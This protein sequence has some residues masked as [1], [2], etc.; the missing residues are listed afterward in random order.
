MRKINPSQLITTKAH[1]EVKRKAIIKVGELKS[2][3]QTINE[4]WL[5]PGMDFLPHIHTDCEEIYF[6]QKG[7]GIL[8][9]DKTVYQVK[10]GDWIVIEQNEEH[11][12]K[13]DSKETLFY[14]SIRVLI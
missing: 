11:S 10:E 6:I 3:V 9:I 14:I 4:A 8:T 12:M 1:N 13:N 5:E 7:L 2:N